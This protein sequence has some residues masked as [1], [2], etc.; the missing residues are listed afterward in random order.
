MPWL[1]PSSPIPLLL[2]RPFVVQYSHMEGADKPTEPQEAAGWA[3]KPAAGAAGAM[4]DAAPAATPAPAN[5][6][7]EWTASEFI[8]HD[9]GV[10]WYVGFFLLT[11]LLAV[12]LYFITRD[13]VSVGGV[14]ALAFILG[15]VAARKPRVLAYRV[16][17]S[18][19]T[20]GSRLHPFGE[21]K[22]F[23]LVNEGPFWSIV[24]LPM[25]RFALP[26][27]LYLAPEQEQ[28]VVEALGNRL[29]L[30]KGELGPLDE[31]MRR[32]HF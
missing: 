9:K 11:A 1:E 13:I 4:V 29:P 3:Y 5:N 8:A 32:V 20:V 16:D 19:I 10:G 26:L 21:Y 15:V 23:A 25:K 2:A 24:F 17:R 18:G 12:G 31:L 14:V 22:S 7:V 28:V 27:S 30:E 6:T